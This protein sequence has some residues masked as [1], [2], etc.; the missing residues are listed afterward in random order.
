MDNNDI[1]KGTDIEPKLETKCHYVK[2]I[3]EMNS[4]EAIQKKDIWYENLSQNYN[5]ISKHKKLDL[6]LNDKK[7]SQME[8]VVV[9]SGTSLDNEI[10][11][12]KKYRHLVKIICIDS[13]LYPLMKNGIKPDFVFFKNDEESVVDLISGFPTRDLKAVSSLL[14]SPAFFKKWQGQNYFYIPYDEEQILNMLSF[15]HPEL[16]KILK[17]P[18]TFS[19]AFI[20]ARCMNFKRIYL[21]GG[22]FCFQNPEKPYCSDVLYKTKNVVSGEVK[23]IENV[24]LETTY[25]TNNLF[26][27][28]E[29]LFRIIAIESVDRVFNCS[30][31]SILYNVHWIYFNEVMKI[32]ESKKTNIFEFAN[33]QLPARPH[34]IEISNELTMNFYK[35]IYVKSLFDNYERFKKEFTIGELYSRKVDFKDK[36]CVI[37]GAG[38]SLTQ[39]LD[40]LKKYREHFVV[41]AVDSTVKPLYNAGIEADYMLT[42]DPCDLSYFIKD[43]EGKNTIM[44]SGLFSHKNVINSWKNKIYFYSTMPIKGFEYWLL[45]IIEGYDKVPFMTPLNNCGSTTV[46]LAHDLGFKT[47]AIM[48]IDFSFPRYRTYAEGVESK[49]AIYDNK[50]KIEK[51]IPNV[52]KLI[53]CMGN[54]VYTNNQFLF[55]AKNLEMVVNAYGINNLTNVGGGILKLPYMNFKNYIDSVIL[56]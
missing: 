31:D 27:Q 37:C 7:W 23:S 4:V 17:K 40:L 26:Y 20:L 19:M 43:Y 10:S 42:I 50:E 18:S 41:F 48:G 30:M 1:K 56:K 33:V 46:L 8:C 15:S 16:P 2:Q 39:N 32:K 54:S 22:D 14:Q 24:L 25:T 55:Y 12:L 28:S 51:E 47:I 35:A 45:S 44:L 11:C 38:P 29:D 5:L 3:L 13:A 49:M 21:L 36:H 9:G 53:D 34:D 6:L 52:A